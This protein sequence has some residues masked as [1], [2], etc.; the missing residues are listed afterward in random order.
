[1][2]NKCDSTPRD[3]IFAVP[4]CG[5][6]SASLTTCLCY[7]TRRRSDLPATDRYLMLSN[8]HVKIDCDVAS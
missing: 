1:M 2:E 4:K 6:H 8:E 3:D 5:S 7:C